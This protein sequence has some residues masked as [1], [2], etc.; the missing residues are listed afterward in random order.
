ML[1]NRIYIFTIWLL[2]LFAVMYASFF[3][4]ANSFRKL[5][6]SFDNNDVYEVDSGVFNRELQSKDCYAADFNVDLSHC[7]INY[8]R[9]IA[10]G[11]DNDNTYV[12]F[13]GYT[14]EWEPVVSVDFSKLENGCNDFLL[15][16][17]D[18]TVGYIIVRGMD[19]N[20]IDTV[21]FRQNVDNINVKKPLKF[22]TII[23]TTYL[24]LSLI[25]L[26]VFKQLHFFEESYIQK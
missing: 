18:F 20:V 8:I 21:E 23:G 3:S 15:S 5:S 4:A 17:T 1:R 22:M 12:T 24:L 11:I 14:D 13:T 7:T 19:K 2:I 6:F 16:E 26:V 9:I 25:V 10:S